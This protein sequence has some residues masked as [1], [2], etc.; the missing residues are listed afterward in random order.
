MRSWTNHWKNKPGYD[1]TYNIEYASSEDSDQPAQTVR[2][3]RLIWVSAKRT[4]YTVG[5][6]TVRVSVNEPPHDITNKMTV[7]QAKTPISLGI[8]PVRS[9][10]S[11]CAQWVAKDLSFLRTDSEDSNQT[12][13]MPRLI[14][15]FAR[16]SHFVGFGAAQMKMP[17]RW[18]SQRPQFIHDTDRKWRQ[19]WLKIIPLPKP[20]TDWKRSGG[21]KSFLDGSRSKS[22]LMD[23]PNYSLCWSDLPGSRSTPVNEQIPWSTCSISI[24]IPTQIPINARRA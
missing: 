7:Q 10:S 16:R 2:M 5:F 3:H 22:V 11:L 18:P 9:E 14:W 6:A 21:E 15:V 8:R 4:Y 24:E 17:S 20:C 13:R 19:M 1:K 23:L 12:G